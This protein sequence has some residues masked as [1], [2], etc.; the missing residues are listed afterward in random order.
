MKN[1]SA[2]KFSSRILTDTYS[3]KPFLNVQKQG[4]LHCSRVFLQLVGVFFLWQATLKIQARHLTVPKLLFSKSAVISG[5]VPNL[6]VPKERYY[7]VHFKGN[8]TYNKTFISSRRGCFLHIWAASGALQQRS[9]GFIPDW[10]VT[11][12]KH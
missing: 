2:F 6:P 5:V 1:P 12:M 9:R 8:V 10:H 7:T 4:G 11:A 3:T